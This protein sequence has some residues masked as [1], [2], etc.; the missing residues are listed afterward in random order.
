MIIDSFYL[1]FKSNADDLIKGNKAVEK[2]TKELGENLK[3]TAEEASKIGQ[4]YVKM[5][6][7]ATQALTALVS[8]RAI[9]GGI[10]NAANTNSNLAVQSKL[11]G[12]SVVDIKAYGAAVEAAGGSAEGFS[13]HLDGLFKQFSEM[14]LKLPAAGMILEK[15]RQQLKQAGGDVAQQEMIFQRLGISDVGLK[16]LLLMSDEEFE[17]STMQQ[18]ELALNTEKGASIAREYAKEWTNTTTALNSVFTSIG[19]DV[20]PIFTSFNKMLQEFFGY[21]KDHERLAEGVF[22]GAAT[23]VTLLSGAIISKLIPALAGVSAAAAPYLAVITAGVAIPNLAIAGGEALGHQIN[24]WRGVGDSN[25][26]IHRGA[27][28][29]QS[30]VGNDLAFWM[31]KGY[32]REQSAAWLAA[33]QAESGNNPRAVGDGG[34]A[35]GL[36]QWH[37]DRRAAIKAATGIDVATAS[38]SEQ[39]EAAAWEAENRGD[40]ARIKSATSASSAAAIHTQFFERPFDIAGESV[41]RGQLA[42][43]IANS[44]PVGAVGGGAGKTISV[45]TGDINVHTAAT[46]ASGIASDLSRELST[47]LSMAIANLDDGVNK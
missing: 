4:Q 6:E 5:V 29:N 17:K 19:T 47:Q 3:N 32:S 14:G 8:F 40:A 10:F 41:K 43:S 44:T 28:G 2:S 36:F 35:M 7:G 27:Q 24:K 20:L 45:K 23:G 34:R 26:V 16:S 21:L 39:L 33:A 18:K 11:I 25:G 1:L 37:P 30:L 12:Q 9:A 42:M 13:S 22:A 38:H 31:S 46:D 15:Y